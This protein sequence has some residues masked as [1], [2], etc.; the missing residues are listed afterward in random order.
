MN[1]FKFL[2]LLVGLFNFYVF[3]AGKEVGTD[4]Q[5][6]GNGGG[7]VVTNSKYMSFYSAG[8][9]V[10]LNNQNEMTFQLPALD[11]LISYI[12]NLETIDLKT[13]GV[14][15]ETMIPS[16]KRK[17]LFAEPEQLT[18]KIYE[19]LMEEFRRVTGVDSTQLKLFAITDT[20]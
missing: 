15:I 7:G 5:E 1:K 14:F 4:G 19:R 12:A 10:K 3:A 2:I 11:D 18:P 9:Y 13:K 8:L 20:V 17:Y 16:S 6:V